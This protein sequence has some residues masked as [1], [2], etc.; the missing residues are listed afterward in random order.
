MVDLLSEILQ[1]GPKTH[2]V[3]QAYR[4]AIEALGPELGILQQMDLEQIERAGIPLLG[5]AIQ[6]MREKR[7]DISPGFDGEYGRVKILPMIS[8][9]LALP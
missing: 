6:R 9:R 5:E 8:A 1:K 4:M 2:K 7:I 3:S